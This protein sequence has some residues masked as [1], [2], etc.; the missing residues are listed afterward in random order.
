MIIIAGRESVELAQ[1]PQE[2]IG[3]VRVQEGLWAQQPAVVAAAIE[4]A[5]AL[6]RS[7]VSD[8]EQQRMQQ[9]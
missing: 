7:H 9:H 4:R 3:K 2:V 8:D 6:Q 5:H 1:R